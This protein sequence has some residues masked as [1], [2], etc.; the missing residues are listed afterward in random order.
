[1]IKVDMEI[2]RGIDRDPTKQSIFGMLV[3]A[4]LHSKVTVLA[5]GVETRGELDYVRANGASL[6][7]GYLFSKPSP[8]PVSRL[9][10][11]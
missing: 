1:M 11:F 2:I 8:E 3:A 7:Q 9:A 5:E 6:A 4:A 10:A